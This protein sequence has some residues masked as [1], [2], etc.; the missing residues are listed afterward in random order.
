[1]VSEKEIEVVA[2]SLSSDCYD[3]EQSSEMYKRLGVHWV[4]IARTALEAAEKVRVEATIKHIEEF[5]SS[6]GIIG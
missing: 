3:L 4:K 1:M 2:K 5:N 6:G